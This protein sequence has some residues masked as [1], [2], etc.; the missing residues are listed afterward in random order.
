MENDSIDRGERLYLVL[1][2]FVSMI[3]AGLVVYSQ[4]A[5]FAWDE[6]FHLLA[7]QL[8]KNGKKP[9][10]DFVFSQTPLNAY[11]NA[12]WMWIGGES[13]RTVHA[14]AAVCTAGAVMLTADFIFR[15]L[16]IPRWR[17]AAALA[18]ACATGMNVLVVDF[19]TIGQAY[20]FCLLLIAAAF[21]VCIVAVD[22]K[23][24]LAAVL[25]GL[26]GGA[27]AASSLL[28]APVA[29]V[30]LLWMVVYNHAGN[31]WAK[32]AGFVAGVI[33]AFLPLIGLLIEAP[34]QV[35]FGVIEYNLRY[36]NLQ[37][38]AAT[39]HNIEVMLS[40]VD[41]SHALLL[42]LLAATGLLYI[43]FKSGWPAAKRAEFYL[44]GWIALGLGIHISIAHP[45]FQRYYLLTVPFLAILAVVGIYWITAQMFHPN[46]PY[47]AVLLFIVLLS[48][49]L[50]KALY[51][52]GADWRWVQME[53]IAKQV[54][55][56]TPHD[57]ALLADEHIYFLSGHRPPSGMELVDSHK[58]RFDAARSELLHVVSSPALR[59][60][61]EAGMFQ[62]VQVCEDGLSFDDLDLTKLYA[63]QSDVE[64]CTVYW[65]WAKH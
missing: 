15:H 41:S 52:E 40:W 33:A 7:A 5:A 56:V 8:I 34:R 29:P 32:A 46:R 4:T 55:A 20:G 26:L 53:A 38:E 45:T 2:A 42:G 1:C 14:V 58:L 9:Y 27:A 59:R 16:P 25:A 49:G 48:F 39:S 50:A 30:L 65:G 21:R 11:W 51:E 57:G 10:L 43:R 13:W 54:N 31:R 62:T 64:D 36:R 18:A 47:P 17:F 3:C 61:V 37:W 6:G 44:C 24:V 12:G 60:S 22:R 23:N 19:G 28:T 63:H 35:F